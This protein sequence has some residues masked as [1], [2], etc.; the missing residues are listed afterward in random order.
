[1]III[2]EMHKL[3]QFQIVLLH[4]QAVLIGLLNY[5]HWICILNFYYMNL[6]LF[7]Y[8]SYAVNFNLIPWFIIIQLYLLIIS[9]A[10][11]Y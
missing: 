9:K 5:D 2:I 4:A 8:R 10:V 1:M 3:Y 6:K 7:G 11:S